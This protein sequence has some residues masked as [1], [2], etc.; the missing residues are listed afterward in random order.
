M[1][2][3]P[4]SKSQ[5]LASAKI[6]KQVKLLTNYQR[7]DG[8]IAKKSTVYPSVKA[9]AIDLQITPGSVSQFCRKGVRMIALSK[10]RKEPL[11]RYGF[12][13]KVYDTKEQLS[14]DLKVTERTVYNWIKDGTIQIIN[15]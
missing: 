5:A 13:G 7:K 6:S 2:R 15:D 12:N 11:T 3:Q 8:T 4:N 14:I 9:A 10:D 1:A